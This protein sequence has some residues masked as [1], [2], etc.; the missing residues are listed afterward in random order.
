MARH[1]L[2]PGI[3]LRFKMTS[4]YPTVLVPLPN[5]LPVRKGLLPEVDVLGPPCPGIVSR[6]LAPYL[7]QAGQVRRAT[8][9]S[10]L[11]LLLRSQGQHTLDVTGLLC[12]GIL[13][14]VT[15]M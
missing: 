7:G 5:L 9:D 11:S 6:T 4:W 12:S 2:P 10:L 3:R 13:R 14:Q 8:V 15:L 1:S